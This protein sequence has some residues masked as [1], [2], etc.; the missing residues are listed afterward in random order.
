MV[1]SRF[2]KNSWRNPDRKK[3][4]KFK[5]TIGKLSPNQAPLNYCLTQPKSSPTLP[6][7]KPLPK[8][9]PPFT[10]TQLIPDQAHFTITELNPDQAPL[11]YCSTQPKPSP[12][13]YSSTQPRPSPTLLLLNSAQIKPHFTIA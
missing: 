9:S 10:I 7:L 4:I 12:L 6:L 11:Y 5:L 13:Y 2:Y 3:I 1:Y 8:P